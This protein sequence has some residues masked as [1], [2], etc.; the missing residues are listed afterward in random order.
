[1]C[2]WL[3]KAPRAGLQCNGFSDLV[4]VPVSSVAFDHRKGRFAYFVHEFIE[5]SQCIIPVIVHEANNFPSLRS[6][7]PSEAKSP[8]ILANQPIMYRGGVTLPDRRKN[9][10]NLVKYKT[11]SWCSNMPLG[12]VFTTISPSGVLR[13]PVFKAAIVSPIALSNAS[14]LHSIWNRSL[15]CDAILL[16]NS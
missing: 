12:F 15:N 3:K 13:I 14:T 11:Q 6:I 4:N 9:I 5:I 7:V 2:L 1:M 8:F 10:D 16:R